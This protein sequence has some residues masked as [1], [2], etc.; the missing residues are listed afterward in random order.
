MSTTTAVLVLAL[1]CGQARDALSARTLARL[2][3]YRKLAGLER[4][5]LDDALSRGCLA[6]AR[7]LARHPERVK[8]KHFSP[9]VEDPRL[10]G[11]TRAGRRAGRNAVIYH[12]QGPGN[13]LRA[14]DEHMAG[15]FHRVP[16]LAP[17]L[18]RIGCALSY[19]P[20]QNCWVVIDVKSG[21]GA[22]AAEAGAPVL[23]PAERQ[24]GVPRKFVGIE[25][26]NP[27][28]PKGVAA[29]SGYPITVIFPPG[30]RV[31]EAAAVLKTGKGKKVAAWV[32]SPDRPAYTP[33]YQFNTVC[34][35]P[36]AH[37]RPRARYRVE[38]RARV[39][40]RDWEKKW[41]F[42]TGRQ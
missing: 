6:H 34:L 15:L 36:R 3:A 30:A 33:R 27:I 19:G 16:L 7:Y 22:A 11:S 29:K 37:L 39:D 26:P 12:L 13:P 14:I 2:N 35:I 38:V 17:D 5:V 28:P 20:G 4:V 42:T 40:G 10:A 23:F 31:T 25:I 32:S 18:K 24:T 41:S 8:A 9:H 1:A 21:K